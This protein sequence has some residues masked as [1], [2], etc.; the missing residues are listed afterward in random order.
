ASEHPEGPIGVRS[1][2]LY[3]E[4]AQRLRGD[5]REVLVDCSLDELDEGKVATG[6]LVV[7]AGGLS[8]GE[9]LLVA[10]EAVVEDGQ[11]KRGLTDP[12]SLASPFRVF[13][14]P[15]E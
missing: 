6:E 9:R 14:G 12:P 2:C 13:N 10:T 5:I 15:R 1:G 11:V 7:L 3:V 4:L 8:A